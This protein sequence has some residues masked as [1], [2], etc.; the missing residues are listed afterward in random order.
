MKE[1]IWTPSRYFA[2]TSRSRTSSWRARLRASATKRPTGPRLA[3]PTPSAPPTPMWW[4]PR[5]WWSTACWA[6]VRLWPWGPGLDEPV[7]ANCHHLTPIG[8]AWARRVRVDLAALRQYAH[9]VY[10]ASDEYLRSLSPDALSLSVDLSARGLR[11]PV[12]GRARAQAAARARRGTAGFA[13]RAAVRPRPWAH[14][15]GVGLGEP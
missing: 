15:Q 4:S 5:T 10:A 7:S 12:E 13:R 14:F 9:A 6:V 2:K 1:Q 8:G 3:P 11:H